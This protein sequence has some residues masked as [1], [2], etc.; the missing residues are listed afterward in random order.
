M[1]VSAV[2]GCAEAPWVRKNPS[3]K[4]QFTNQLASKEISLLSSLNNSVLV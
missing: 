1:K 3:G 2:D 4:Y